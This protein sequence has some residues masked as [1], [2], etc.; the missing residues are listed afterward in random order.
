MRFKLK[1]ASESTICEFISHNSDFF[2]QK[3][4]KHSKFWDINSE[5]R[6]EKKS[7]LWDK[8]FILYMAEISFYILN[9]Y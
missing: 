2:P 8:R 3:F 6:D 1:I 9:Q 4:K 7:E 5:L